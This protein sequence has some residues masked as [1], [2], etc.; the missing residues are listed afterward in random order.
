MHTKQQIR[1]LLASAGIRPNKRLG[2]H[3]LIDLNLMQMLTDSAQIQSGDI[4][5][6]VGCGTGSLTE[7]LAG[8]AGAVYAVEFDAALAEI[9]K[10]QLTSNKNVNFL[11]IDILRNKHTINP[12][13]AEAI[14]S[15]R[16]NCL[17]RLLL[18]A[19]LPFNVAS[20][21]ILN[22]VK[23]PTIADAMYVT[24]Q[25]EVA[26]RMTARPGGRDYGILS[27]FLNAAG[28]VKMIRTLKPTVFWPTPKVDSAMVTFVR[29]KT[30]AR[31]IKSM[32]IFSEL[33]T[34]LMQHRRKML[35]AC[36]KFAA[37]ELAKI[38]DWQEIFENCSIDSTTRPQQIP[39]QGYIAVSNLC[40]RRLEQINA[41]LI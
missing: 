24:V 37:G 15:A 12:I 31:Q 36:I 18:V 23:G 8:R 16:K 17:G 14:E 21:V 35:K 27:I 5:L 9:A 28:D 29:K 40:C 7:Q 26:R 32:K 30:K 39:P 34:L 22:L 4:V 6:E 25:K 1:Q 3:F 33:V 19:N 13:V 11:N 2:Q 10:K 20:P 38:D 41:R